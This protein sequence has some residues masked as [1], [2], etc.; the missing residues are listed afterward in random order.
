[1]RASIYY[2]HLELYTRFVNEKFFTKKLNSEKEKITNKYIIV[3]L[4]MF[5]L[6][7]NCKTIN[8][9]NYFQLI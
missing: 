7:G 1:M 8:A 9:F 6:Q 4:T 5:Y 2:T 3:D